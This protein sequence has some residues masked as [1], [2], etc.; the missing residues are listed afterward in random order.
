MTIHL[1]VLFE[2]LELFL[3]LKKLKKKADADISTFS[4]ETCAFLKELSCPYR[5]LLEG[6]IDERFKSVDNKLKLLGKKMSIFKN[7]LQAR[8]DF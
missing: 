4:L 2:C 8:G 7:V 3:F 1:S 6:P 5:V